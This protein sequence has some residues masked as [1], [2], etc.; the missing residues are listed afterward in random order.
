MSQKLAKVNRQNAERASEHFLYHVYHCEPSQIIRAVK[1]RYQRQDLW[2]A[3]TAGRTKRS[4][5]F[6][7]QVTAGGSEALRQRRRKLEKICWRPDETVLVLQLVERPDP[8]NARKKQFYFRIHRLDTVNNM[9][10]V[11]DRACFVPRAWFR[12]LKT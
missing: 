12:K 5:V 4:E 10:T 11:D 7:A 1:T 3:D 2:A 9:W 6:Y 8:A